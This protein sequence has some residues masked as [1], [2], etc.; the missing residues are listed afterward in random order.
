MRLGTLRRRLNGEPPDK[1]TA[2]PGFE[3]T[4]SSWVVVL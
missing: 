2:N 1:L 3:A 4:N